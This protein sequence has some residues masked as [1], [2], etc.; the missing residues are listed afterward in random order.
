MQLNLCF[1]IYFMSQESLKNK[2]I[3]G[4]AWSSADAFLGQ[5]MTFLVGIVL[6]RLLSPDEYGLLGICLIF[7]NVL[8][9]IVDSGFS[10][11]LIRKK[12]VTNIDYNTMFITNL[13]ISVALYIAL[14]FFSPVISQF[15]SRS[16]LTVLLRVVGLVLFANALSITQVTILTKKSILKPRLKHLYYLQ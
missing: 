10:N 4:T 2:T 11:A 7:T 13:A 8:N 1:I 6:A 9:G 14:F 15:F 5:G 3:K 12:D 16:E